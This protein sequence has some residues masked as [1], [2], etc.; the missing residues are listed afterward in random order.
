MP[1]DF[2]KLLEDAVDGIECLTDNEREDADSNGESGSM[3]VTLEDGRKFRISYSR[4]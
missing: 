2:T 1:E 3:V 4:A